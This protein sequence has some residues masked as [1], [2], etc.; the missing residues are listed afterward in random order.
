MVNTSDR[1]AKRRVVTF[2]LVNPLVRIV[3]TKEVP[4]QRRSM[5]PEAAEQHRTELL[6]ERK[7]AEQD[8]VCVRSSRE[9]T[10]E[11]TFVF[12]RLR[13]VIGPPSGEPRNQVVGVISPLFREN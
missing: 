5:S 2:L 4:D 8:G 12:F 9:S 13:A 11:C 3:S 1:V 6:K 10:S 7:L